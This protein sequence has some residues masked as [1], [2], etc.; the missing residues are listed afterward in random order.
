MQIKR[1]WRVSIF[2][3]GI[4]RPVNSCYAGI[5][6]KFG[7]IVRGHV[8]R[9]VFVRSTFCLACLNQADKEARNLYNLA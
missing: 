5:T 7:K 8:F 9:K 1:T 4:H 2:A 6:G 3:Q